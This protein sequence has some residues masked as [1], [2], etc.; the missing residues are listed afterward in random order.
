MNPHSTSTPAGVTGPGSNLTSPLPSKPPHKPR[1]PSTKLA[2]GDAGQQA[3]PGTDRT[4]SIVPSFCPQISA[5]QTGKRQGAQARCS[6]FRSRM[7]LW[8]VSNTTL[9][10]MWSSPVNSRVCWFREANTR[11]LWLQKRESPVALP[12]PA[13]KIS[14]IIYLIRKE[15]CLAY[16]LAKTTTITAESNKGGEIWS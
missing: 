10:S 3:P 15:K 9:T 8:Y 12:S 16:R 11:N 4:G 1:L 13:K 5:S 7:H 2:V 6:H 14:C